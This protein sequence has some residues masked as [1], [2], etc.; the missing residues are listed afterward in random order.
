MTAQRHEAKLYEFTR[1]TPLRVEIH[2]NDCGCKDCAPWGPRLK[3]RAIAGW[4]AG[5]FVVGHLIA[6]AYDARGMLGVWRAMIGLS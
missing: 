5:G 3:D 4:C 1:P 2:A 6:F